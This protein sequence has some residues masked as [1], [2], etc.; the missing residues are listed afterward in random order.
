MTRGAPGIDRALTI[1]TVLSTEPERSFTLAEIVRRTGLSKAT[2][3]AL[4]TSLVDARWLLRHP[5]GP[6]YRLGP[7]LIALG[8]AAQ[9]GFPALRFA[10]DA[11]EALCDELDLEG[12]VTAVVGAEILVLARTGAPVPM[13][14]SVSPGQRVPL[15]PPLATV[16]FAWSDEDEIAEAFDS[17][18]GE[19]SVAVKRYRR[20]LTAVRDRGFTVGLESPDRQRLGRALAT[21]VAKGRP[22]A[23]EVASLVTALARSEYQLVELDPGAT[24]DVNH[25]AVP[26]FDA[27]GRVALALTITGFAEPLSS[28]AVRRH[29]ARL[30]ATAHEVM[31]GS[32]GAAPEVPHRVASS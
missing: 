26:V 16:F 6:A 17:W 15:L 7:G 12:L 14:I 4:L 1:L 27:A 29:G 8:E 21:Q 24:Y 19:A 25:L 23:P 13:T 2:C 28:A 5:V 20:A 30:L 18:L 10:E 32:G 31:V 3:H 11:L 9:R 22:A